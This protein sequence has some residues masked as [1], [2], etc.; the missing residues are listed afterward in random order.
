MFHLKIKA[1]NY[2]FVQAVG[3]NG[4][5]SRETCSLPHTSVP[6]FKCITFWKV[7]LTCWQFD[8]ELSIHSSGNII[9]RVS[10]FD[11]ESTGFSKSELQIY[12]C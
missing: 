12:P 9:Y 3:L 2:P 11:T 4:Y 8:S 5:E 1:Q 6:Q 7:L 10:L